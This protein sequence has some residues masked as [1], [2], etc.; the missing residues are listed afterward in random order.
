MRTLKT[1]MKG[2]AVTL[3]GWMR[4]AALLF[5]MA[6]PAAAEEKESVEWW[7]SEWTVRKKIVVDAGP[8]GAAISDQIGVAP[9][10]MRLHDGNFQFALA[11]EDGSDLRFVVAEGK[12]ELPFH[13]EKLDALMGEAFVWVKLPEMKAGE[14]ATLWMYYGNAKAGKAEEAKATYDVETVGVYHFAHRNALTQDSSLAG[15]N[16]EGTGVAADGAMIG[17][18]LRLSGKDALK[19]PGSGAFEWTQGGGATVSLWVKPSSPS[20]TMVLFSRKEDGRAFRIGL[21]QGVLYAEVSDGT[22]TVRTTGGTPLL[23]N[24]W[25]HVAVVVGDGALTV[26]LGGEKYGTAAANLPAIKAV[27][28]LGGDVAGGETGFTGDVDELVL[29]KVARPAGYIQVLAMSQGPDKV[30]KLVTAGAD[31]QASTWMSGTF[32]ILMRSLTVDGWIV[33]AILV[34]MAVISWWVMWGKASYLN[35]LEKGNGTFM[36][37]WR[38]LARDLTLLD[39]ADVARVNTLGGHVDARG[40]KQMRQS[41]VFRIYHVGVEEMR[42]RLAADRELGT[43]KALSGRSIQAIRASLDGIMVRETQKLNSL[44]VLLTIA[45]SGGPFLGLLGTVVGVMI[46]FASI[47]AAGDVNVNAIAPGIA[48]ALVATVA[49]LFVAIPAMFGYNYLT[50]KIKEATTDMH[51]FVDEFITKVAEFYRE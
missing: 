43:R 28:H 34:V 17:G 7:N 3:V 6:M 9:L 10:L 22:N 30:A 38:H 27:G 23:A 16:A 13:L 24:A 47:A 31:E 2:G 44:M 50:S 15:N 29:S 26:Y 51:V 1:S 45:I 20:G 14:S 48:A 46:T 49:G 32:G 41:S 37:A 4:W 19:I 18:G 21:D 39:D 35:G 8:K 25:V 36:D 5:A 11:R 33:I 42:H 12:K 40:L